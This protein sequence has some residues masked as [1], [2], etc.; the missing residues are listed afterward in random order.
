MDKSIN[1]FY[2]KILKLDFLRPILFFCISYLLLLLTTNLFFESFVGVKLELESIPYFHL[3]DDPMIN[4]RASYNFW[5]NGKPY[6]NPD[7]SV[8]AISTL[9]WPIIIS[10]IFSL[11]KYEY[12]IVV[13]LIKYINLFSYYLFDL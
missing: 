3:L 5:L 11:V 2:K 12:V 13:L 4:F 10:P 7:E 6:I 1:N 8:S 9:F